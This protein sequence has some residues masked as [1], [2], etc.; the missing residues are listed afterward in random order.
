MK[1]KSFPIRNSC[2]VIALILAIA[3]AGHAQASHQSSEATRAYYSKTQADAG[4]MVYTQNCGN[5]HLENLKGSCAE[6]M[7]KFPKTYVCAADGSA[8]PLIGASF[9]ERYYSVA[10]LYSRTKWSMPKDNA[11]GLS[12]ADNLR[13]VAFLLQANGLPSGERDLKPDTEAMKSMAMDASGPAM[14]AAKNS[15]A[16]PVNSAG[17]S[18][19]YYTEQQAER[20]RPY[21]HAACGVCHPAELS[22]PHGVNMTP[23]TG[24]G[25]HYGS[26]HRYTL[27]SGE[28]WL[29]TPS[30]ILGRPQRWDT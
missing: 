6:E 25:W 8:P 15:V 24:L 26:Q 27:L 13:I 21:F 19:A 17:I 22:S 4:K 18:R 30:G 7:T 10:D 11:N 5:C 28:V 20:G 1:R 2:A 3:L 14:H 23:S 9:M 16:D 29:T 12:V